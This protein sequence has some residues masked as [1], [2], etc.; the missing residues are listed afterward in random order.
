M[1]AMH[2]QDTNEEHPS[3]HQ[4]AP[5]MIGSSMSRKL[6]P[7]IVE[8]QSNEKGAIESSTIVSNVPSS[9]SSF[10]GIWPS[11]R[12][13]YTE[14]TPASPPRR[15]LGGQSC[16]GKLQPTFGDSH[17]PKT[18]PLHDT[19]ETQA[20][21]PI[22][23]SLSS[24]LT[25]PMTTSAVEMK[26]SLIGFGVESG[27]NKLEDAT[28]ASVRAVQDALRQSVLS[29]PNQ[30]SQRWQIYIKLGVP[31]QQ[32]GSSASL[33]P[34]TVNLARLR[35]VLPAAFTL[36]PINVVVGGLWVGGNQS[37]GDMC[38]TVASVTIQRVAA[39]AQPTRRATPLPRPP[40]LKAPSLTAS[41]KFRL[42]QKSQHTD[43]PNQAFTSMDLLARI[44]EEVS[45][46]RAHTVSPPTVPHGFTSR[47]PV[48]PSSTVQDLSSTFQGSSSSEK[49][50]TENLSPAGSEGNNRK[51]Y[52][53]HNYTDHSQE[54]PKATD[55]ALVLAGKNYNTA[56]PAK[57]YEVL[58]KLDQD[59]RGHIMSWQPHGRSFKI[60]KPQEFVDLVLP[61]YFVMTKKSSFLRQLNLYGFQR[62][63]AGPDKGTYYHEL[64]LRGVRFLCRRMSRNKINGNRVRAAG[65]PDQEPNFYIMRPLTATTSESG[66][67]GNGN[68]D[69]QACSPILSSLLIPH[70]LPEGLRCQ[71]LSNHLSFP[72]KLQRM[73]DT[74]ETEGNT[75]IISWLPHGRGFIVKQQDQ[76]VTELMPKYFRQTK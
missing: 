72:R 56:F 71:A 40:Q 30:S 68:A 55:G 47:I 59:G 28:E 11:S 3:I 61:Q 58:S 69:T 76:F 16:R 65:N 53:Q 21:A 8:E 26:I 54:K 66:G 70:E 23:G 6:L 1:L 57:L 41:P 62:I 46:S 48:D 20:V 38:T 63:S 29:L 74:L 44:S 45:Q 24:S 43:K 52:V 25:P 34:M 36:M 37:S 19:E 67:E 75:D 2:R 27:P 5:G 9:K 42:Q 39:A 7:F 60:H 73:L 49:S 4:L 13:G 32:N 31:P 22:S 17:L 14:S 12:V 33:E 15:W 35:S 64:F 51:Q 50:A 18:P 10:T